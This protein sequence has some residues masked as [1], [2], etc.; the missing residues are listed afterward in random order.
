MLSVWQASGASGQKSKGTNVTLSTK[1]Q[2]RVFGLGHI[3][4]TIGYIVEARTRKSPDG[5]RRT[6]H[7]KAT[8]FLRGACKAQK[9]IRMKMSQYLAESLKETGRKSENRQLPQG[10][11][12]RAYLGAMSIFQTSCGPPSMVLMTSRVLCSGVALGAF[13]FLVWRVP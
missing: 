8:P 7:Q 10:Q 11:C 9:V 5:F 4:R 6:I 13:F 12:H 1:H 2:V 3:R